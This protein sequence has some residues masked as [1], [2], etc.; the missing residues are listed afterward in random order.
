MINAKLK[1][2]KKSNKKIDKE[3][4]CD[5]N[6]KQGTI[7]LNCLKPIMGIEI[8]SMGKNSIESLL[9][10]NW[11]VSKNKNKILLIDLDG[12]GITTGAIINFNGN[13]KINDILA[14]TTTEECL[15]QYTLNDK[16]LYIWERSKGNEYSTNTTNWDSL[17]SENIHYSTKKLSKNLTG[18]K[19]STGLTGV[20]GASGSATSYTGGE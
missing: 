2:A 17:K 3:T 5:L 1:R 18:T 16:D 15:T 19:G 20:T 11:L 12:I 10:Q 9:P 4:I 8:T 6:I 7:T 13:L 14:V